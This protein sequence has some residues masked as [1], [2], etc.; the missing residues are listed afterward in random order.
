MYL[1]KQTAPDFLE[2]RRCSV[3]ALPG[4]GFV[5]NASAGKMTVF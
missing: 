3:F 5:S 1:H 4:K 2:L